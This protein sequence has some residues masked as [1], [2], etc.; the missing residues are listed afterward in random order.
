[1]LENLRASIFR[2]V[3]GR[4]FYGWAIL[5]SASLIMFGTGP[6]QSHLIGLFFDPIQAEL[7]LSRTQIAGAYGAATLVAALLLPRMGRLVDR[8]GPARMIALIAFGLGLAAIGFSFATGWIYLAIGFGALRF[9]GQGSLMLNC[10]NLTS[11]WFDR[12]RGFAIGLMTLGF[13]ISIALHPPVVQ[14]LIAEVGWREAWIWLGVWTWVMLIPV[15]LL[16]LHNKPED[17]GLRPDGEAPLAEGATAPP[18]TGHTRAEALRMPAFYLIVAG[19]FS[20]SML[21]TSLHVEYTGI[22]KAHGL[23]PQTAASMF[24]VS[25]VTAAILMPLVGRLLDRWPTKWMYFGGLWVM[26]LSL[27][28][29]TFVT[30]VPSAIAFAAIFGLNN[31]VTITYVSYLW[32]RYFGR[33]HLGSIQGTGQMI[34]IFGASLGPLPLG[35]ALDNWGGY[36]EMLQLTAMLPIAISLLVAFLMPHPNPPT[37][38]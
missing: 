7:G 1:M 4:T 38:N 6:G 30:S 3:S 5:A 33:A 12:K 23:E 14:W 36:D 13:P 9:L 29:A 25:G 11:Q 24:I 16:F 15:A 37:N 10:G 8:H 20:L 26:A 35:W 17:V 2:R 18:A 28:S 34:V 19:M 27:L 31:A 32:P 22:L 21:V